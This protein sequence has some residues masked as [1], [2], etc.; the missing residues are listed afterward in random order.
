MAQKLSSPA[1]TRAQPI[2]VLVF[3]FIELVGVPKGAQLVCSW[4]QRPAVAVCRVA[5]PGRMGRERK[6][7][8][9]AALSTIGNTLG[10]K[11]KGRLYPFTFL[12]IELIALLVE[13]TT[14]GTPCG[15]ICPV[16]GDPTPAIDAVAVK[17]KITGAV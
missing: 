6:S 10:G 7:R 8:L 3:Y 9:T 4:R 5:Y 16:G 2:P 15:P 13:L 17:V 1:V 12:G 14:P 11:H